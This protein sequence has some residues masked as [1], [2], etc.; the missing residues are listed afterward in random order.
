MS[1]QAKLTLYG[2]M[3]AAVGFL[4]T[5]PPIVGG[6][7]YAITVLGFA[8]SL[9]GWRKAAMEGSLSS[10]ASRE[11]LFNKLTQYAGILLVA[12]SVCGLLYAVDNDK[13]WLPL[14]PALAHIAI[15]E[16]QSIWENLIVLEKHGVPMGPLK[17]WIEKTR[18][19]FAVY[20]PEAPQSPEKGDAEDAK[21]NVPG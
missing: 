12:L 14:I 21:A 20:V 7:L 8:D 6:L 19:M 15:T 17:P 18:A 3:T 1:P 11:M 2:L 10:K 9:T 5:A 16:L 13:T 4:H